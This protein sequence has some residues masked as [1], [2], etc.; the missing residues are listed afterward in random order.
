[1]KLNGALNTTLIWWLKT[2]L[3]SLFSF[4][5]LIISLFFSIVGPVDKAAMNGETNVLDNMVNTRPLGLKE[6]RN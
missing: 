3:G 2:L 5:K 1:M 4:S 6:K